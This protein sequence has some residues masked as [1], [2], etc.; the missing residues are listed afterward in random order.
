MKRLPF[1]FFFFLIAVTASIVGI[2][3]LIPAK[4]LAL[5]LSIIFA[6]WEETNSIFVLFWGATGVSGNHL[7]RISFASS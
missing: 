2:I 4:A 5:L 3:A 1:L 7:K 6:L